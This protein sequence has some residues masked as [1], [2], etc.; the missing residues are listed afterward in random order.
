VSA[1]DGVTGLD[2]SK[3]QTTT[4]RLVGHEFLFARATI[5]TKRDEMYATHIAN[6]RAAGLLVGAYHFNHAPLS[7]SSQV[8]AFLDAAGDVDFYALDVEGA[9]AFSHAQA[10]DFIKRV[11]ATGRKCGLYHSLSGFFD[12]GQDF[13]W[14]AYWSDQPPIRDWD[15][16]QFGP[17]D[18]I[19]GNR[20]GGTLDQL[21]ALA[22][23]ETDVTIP[24]SDNTAD[25]LYDV[26]VKAGTQLYDQSFQPLVKMSRDAIVP[27]YFVTGTG[28]VAINIKTSDVRQLAFVKAATVAYGPKIIPA[29]ILDCSAEVAE[30]AAVAWEDGSTHG[31]EV[32]QDR[33]RTLLGL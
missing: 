30:A 14:I 13:D 4:P 29:T 23:K 32:E 3:W 20:F 24:I 17:I 6:A 15:I 1:T 31:V 22:G 33:L 12:A 25:S 8:A 16:W 28:Y 2:V 19:D 5:G 10:A 7:I 18:G 26:T 27:G 9:D 21:K 11:Q